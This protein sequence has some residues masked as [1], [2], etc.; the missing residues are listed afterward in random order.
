MVPRRRAG[1]GTPRARTRLPPRA[2]HAATATLGAGT[3]CPRR[4]RR[5]RQAV[6]LLVRSLP[7]SARVRW[8]RYAESGPEAWKVHESF[9]AERKARTSC[10]RTEAAGSG[11]HQ[12]TEGLE[13]WYAVGHRLEDHQH[14]DREHGAPGAP[15]PRPEQD[16]EEDGKH[17]H[18]LGLAEPD[19]RQEPALER[20][21]GK[22]AA[23]GEQR[24]RKVAGLCPDHD[25]QPAR[26]Q[27]RPG[28]RDGI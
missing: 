8:Y 15:H 14:R 7:T 11:R 10:R 17:V 3:P 19:R 22:R 16:A 1:P 21:H 20:G 6:L 28:I 9:H 13:R 4:G 25:E 2:R 23:G 26:D 24:L 12:A 27:Y 5:S 18:A